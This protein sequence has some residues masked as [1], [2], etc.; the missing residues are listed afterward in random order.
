MRGVRIREDGPPPYEQLRD[1]IRARIERGSLLPGDRVP[2]VRGLADDLDLAP[3]TVARAYRELEVGG[4]LEGRGRAGT[5]VTVTA[6]ATMGVAERA[7]AGAADRYLRRAAQL[8]FDRAA[9]ARALRG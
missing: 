7:L 2:T 5:F 3:N 8:G 1:A 9:A 4:W 6:P